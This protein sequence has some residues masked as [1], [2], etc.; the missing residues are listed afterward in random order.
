MKDFFA[1]HWFLILVIIASLFII[2][3]LASNRKKK[4]SDEKAEKEGKKLNVSMDG[5]RG[6]LWT[7]FATGCVVIIVC[8]AIYVVKAVGSWGDPEPKGE[9]VASAHAPVGYWG[10]W[11]SVPD[12]YM[13]DLQGYTG[14]ILLQDKYFNKYICERD[15]RGKLLYVANEKGDVLKDGFIGIT[16]DDTYSSLRF[17]AI[18]GKEKYFPIHLLPYR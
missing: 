6:F 5:V 16:Q 12:H 13:A 10:P 18:D 7:L 8:F 1:N 15:S 11:V 9:K 14:K 3:S 4:S 17:Q 2:Y